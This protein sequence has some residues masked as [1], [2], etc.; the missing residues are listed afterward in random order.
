MQT[1]IDKRTAELLRYRSELARLTDSVEAALMFL[2]E[3]HPTA[4][5]SDPCVELLGRIAAA[6]EV[7][8]SD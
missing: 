1:L 8:D 5:A 4:A 3:H 2:V 6:Q 7:L